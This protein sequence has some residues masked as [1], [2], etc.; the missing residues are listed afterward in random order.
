MLLLLV[1]P[2]RLILSLD[3]CRKRL[4]TWYGTT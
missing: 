4:V 3:L 1:P 2:K